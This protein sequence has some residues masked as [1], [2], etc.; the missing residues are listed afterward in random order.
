MLKNPVPR[1]LLPPLRVVGEGWGG[2][3]QPRAEFPVCG[4][5]TQPHPGPPLPMQGRERVGETE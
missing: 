3:K 4:K 1:Y 2:V 5:P